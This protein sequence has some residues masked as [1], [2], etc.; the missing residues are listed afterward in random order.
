MGEW[1]WRRVEEPGAVPVTTLHGPKTVLCR[2]WDVGFDGS[3]GEPELIA[4][5]PAMATDVLR[6]LV[7]AQGM[8]VTSTEF[9]IMASDIA[10]EARA[11]LA[12]IDRESRD[13]E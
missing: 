11:I 10:D 1:K 8:A 7:E 13:D 6:K 4:E 9:G 12:R 3:N 2:Y 5:A